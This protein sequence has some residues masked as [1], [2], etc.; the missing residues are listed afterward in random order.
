MS[1]VMP[2]QVIMTQDQGQ[3]VPIQNFMMVSSQQ[4]RSVEKNFKVSVLEC[5]VSS[6]CQY[7]SFLFNCSQI[8]ILLFLSAFKCSDSAEINY[9]RRVIVEQQSN[10]SLFCGIS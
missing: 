2:G 8:S 3:P 10:R 4:H 9:T 6:V 1:P 7:I 5:S